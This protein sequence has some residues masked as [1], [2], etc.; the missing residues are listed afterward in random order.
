M[1]LLVAVGLGV[2]SKRNFKTVNLTLNPSPLGE[3]LCPLQLKN[4]IE[5]NQLN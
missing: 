4:R 5:I 2:R 3:G 1:Y